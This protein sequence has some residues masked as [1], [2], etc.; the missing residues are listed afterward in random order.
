MLAESLFSQYGVLDNLQ[1]DIRE[2]IKVEMVSRTK[3]DTRIDG[4]VSTSPVYFR[5]LDLRVKSRLVN[6][7]QIGP[8]CVLR[9][10]DRHHRSG[11]FPS[12]GLQLGSRRT[13]V[14]DRQ[15]PG[16]EPLHCYT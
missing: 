10:G 6:G 2:V 15:L 8:Y 16:G 9:L 5:V 12:D 11:T 13:T 1:Q 14:D 4:P 3:Q 7:K